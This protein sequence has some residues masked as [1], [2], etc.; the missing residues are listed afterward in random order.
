MPHY[1]ICA[2]FPK[3]SSSSYSTQS[4]R[5]IWDRLCTLYSRNFVA[6]NTFRRPPFFFFFRSESLASLL[7]KES[8]GYIV[9]HRHIQAT[10]LR[11]CSGIPGRACSAYAPRTTSNIT[12]V[13]F[14][15]LDKVM[16]RVKLRFQCWR[17]EDP[18]NTPT[19]PTT[20]AI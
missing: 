3:G 17:P 15:A 9:T 12:Y 10:N 5:D 1:I 13:V 8:R 7:R 19:A 20:P 11:L 6:Y 16:N 2:V 4:Q 14:F 18:N